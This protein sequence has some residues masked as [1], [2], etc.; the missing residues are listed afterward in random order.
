[1]LKEKTNFKRFGVMLDCSRN[2]VMKVET[3]KRFIDHL[4]IMGYNALEL[5]TEDTYEIKDEPRFGYLRGRYTGEEIK[6]QSL[7]SSGTT[8]RR[9]IATS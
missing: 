1:M 9:W 3:V 2:A 5:Y 8:P 6:D 4:Q 7:L